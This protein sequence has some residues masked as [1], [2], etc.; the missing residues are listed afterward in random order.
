MLSLYKISGFFQY[1]FTH[2]ITFLNNAVNL[3]ID[4]NDPLEQKFIYKHHLEDIVNKD[5]NESLARY[6]VFGCPPGALY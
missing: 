6:Q 1:T 3:A 4:A 2:Q 5:T